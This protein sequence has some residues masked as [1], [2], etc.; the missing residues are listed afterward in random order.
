MKIEHWTTPAVGLVWDLYGRY[1]AA[2]RDVNRLA[3]QRHLMTL[4]E[5]MAVQFDPRIV[6]YIAYGDDGAPIGQSC[7]TD[8]LDAWPLI[9]PEYFEARWPD[10]YRTRRIFYVGYVGAH[11]DARV[12]TNRYGVFGAL[13]A[14]MA[15]RVVDVAGVAVMDVCARNLWK[16]DVPAGAGRV[17]AA[18][19]DRLRF[20]PIDRQEFWAYRFDGEEP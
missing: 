4:D 7:I 8:D 5:F 14:E 3:A 16:P 13:L 15:P 18:L 11:V 9:S 1:D 19:S 6:K 17:L 10:L 20:G 12:R 2:F